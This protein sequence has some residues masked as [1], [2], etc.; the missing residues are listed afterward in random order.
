ML[1]RIAIA[2]LLMLGMTGAQAQDKTIQ[3]K[4]SSWVPP[5][6]PLNPALQGWAADIDK[7]SGGT[8]KSTLF[9]SEQLGKAMDHYDMARDGIADFAYVNPG[10]QPG[11]FPIIARGRTAIPGARANGAVMLGDDFER[12]HVRDLIH[13]DH[14]GSEAEEGIETLGARKVARIFAEYVERGK[15][16]RRCVAENY[17]SNLPGGYEAAGLA[18]DD[19]EFAL[20]IHVVREMGRRQNDIPSGL[21]H[22]G[23]RLHEAARF[24]RLYRL[25][26]LCVRVV[27]E[28]DAPDFRR[29]GVGQAR[30]HFIERQRGDVRGVDLRLRTR[31]DNF[32]QIVRQTRSVFGIDLV[33]GRDACACQYAGVSFAMM[34]KSEKLHGL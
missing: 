34:K 25:N 32:E 10:Y 1:N 30:S 14:H 22:A 24:F 9:P 13:S 4:L 3:L 33:N 18:D 17:L 5:A 7:A 16:E 29:Y 2:M 12:I 20:G 23:S 26:I 6:H 27:V 31:A 15:V 19:A 8:I 11:R 28:S 21:E